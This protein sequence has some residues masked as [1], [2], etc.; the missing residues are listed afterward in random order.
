MQKSLL[1]TLRR[2]LAA[3][4]MGNRRYIRYKLRVQ[5]KTMNRSRSIILSAL[6]VI[7]ALAV[8]SSAFG[9][10]MVRVGPLV[11]RADGEFTPRELPQHTYVPIRFQ[12]HAD[13]KMTNSKPPPALRR[14]VLDFD[15]DGRLTT[16]GLAVCSP[17]E[18]AGTTPEEARQRCKAAIIGTGHVAAVIALPDRERFRVESPL[19]LFNGPRQDGNVTVVSHAQVTAPIVET[20]VVV[21]PI[22]RRS[23]YF[24]YRA[25]IDIPSIAG[26]YGALT[27][28][29]GKLGK[30][31][32]YGGK[33]R[34][35]TSARC[36]D[37]ILLTHGLLSFADGNVISGDLFKPCNAIG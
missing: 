8:A 11:I 2:A 27:H 35:Y 21:V 33:A 3:T 24:S 10:A 25:T 37:G 7:C 29:D 32:R 34:S 31:Y 9:G 15:R 17:D 28:I 18:I 16:G 5:G 26:G 1:R 14:A 30:R 12:G 6:V 20:Y 22:E 13:I 19:T 23:G 4:P 36:S